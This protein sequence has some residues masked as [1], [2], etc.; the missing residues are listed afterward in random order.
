MSK[1]WGN[2]ADALQRALSWQERE[3][4][5]RS[6]SSTVGLLTFHFGGSLI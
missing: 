6:Y 1:G 3:M 2:E 5:L 4:G